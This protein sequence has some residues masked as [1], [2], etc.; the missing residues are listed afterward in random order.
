MFMLL[1][2]GVLSHSSEPRIAHHSS[3]HAHD[4]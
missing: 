2:E 4:H 1:L 3:I